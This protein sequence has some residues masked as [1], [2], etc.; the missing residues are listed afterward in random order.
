MSGT[1]SCYRVKVKGVV[2]CKKNRIEIAMEDRHPLSLTASAAPPE[3]PTAREGEGSLQ[4]ALLLL[5]HIAIA[6]RPMRFVDL[7]NETPFPKA[8]LHRLLKTLVDEGML[9]FDPMARE[10]AL[11][12]RVMRLAHAA[13]RVSS[14]TSAAKAALDALSAR[15]GET[16]HLA[17]LDGCQ[18]LYLDKRS[19]VRVVSMYS[20]AGKV[21][22]AYCTGVGKA[23]LSALGETQLE[24]ALSKQALSAF[25]ANTITDPRSLREELVKIRRQGYAIDNEEHEPGIICVAK[26]ILSSRNELFGGLSITGSTHYIDLER[27]AGFLPDLATAVAAIAENAE[28]LRVA[29]M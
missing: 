11:G 9:A 15:T 24:T 5:D 21:A 7:L 1:L 29:T 2:H 28:V 10:Y 16:L 26:P 12:M 4:K 14:L 25:T 8:T 19:A 27:L 3:K 18:V 22:P 23:M 20:S 13:W 6:G 17:T